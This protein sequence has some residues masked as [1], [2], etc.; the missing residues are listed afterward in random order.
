MEGCERHGEEESKT[1][2]SNSVRD[3]RML[4]DVERD[5]GC[6]GH[7]KAKTRRRGMLKYRYGN[8]LNSR[9]GEMRKTDQQKDEGSE[10]W[11]A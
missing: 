5:R 1:N 6:T 10:Q 2:K 8:F 9:W 11:V 4:G 3:I 7:G